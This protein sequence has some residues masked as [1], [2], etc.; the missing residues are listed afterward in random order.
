MAT[1][2]SSSRSFRSLLIAVLLMAIYSIALHCRI[3]SAVQEEYH[4]RAGSRFL[5]APRK[6]D[7]C[8]PVRSNMCP[9]IRSKDGTQLL[10]YCC[11]NHCR[12]VLSDR[13]NCGFCGNKCGFGQLCCSGKCTAVAYDVNNCGQCGT[14]CPPGLRCEYGSCGYA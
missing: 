13:N 8:D 2:T 7:R 10:F 5:A 1:T 4:P 9:G 11:K 14:A 3:A 6:G 12:N